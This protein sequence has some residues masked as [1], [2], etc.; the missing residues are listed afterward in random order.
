M[1]RIVP[2]LATSGAIPGLSGRS[3]NRV[4]AHHM[5]RNPASGCVLE[6]PDSLHLQAAQGGLD[7]GNHVEA[8]E[9][10]ERITPQLR[11]HPDVLQVRWRIYRRTSGTPASTLPRP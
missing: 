1:N 6:P 9:E 8:N 5:V 3:T 10:L 2:F 4:R 11:A 7:L